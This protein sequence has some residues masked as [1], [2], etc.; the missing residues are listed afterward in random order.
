MN[1]SELLQ[2]IKKYFDIQELV[3][4]KTFGVHGERAWKF[5]DPRLLETMLIL[6]KNI[7]KSIYSNNW[8]MGGS[9]D[10]RGLRHN[11]STIVKDKTK[12][13]SLYLS[14]H[15]LGMAIDFDVSGMTAEQVRKWI[16]KNEHLFPYKIRLEKGVSWVHLDI[17]FEES[18]PKI[19]EFAV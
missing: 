5:F 18:N 7:G 11:L 1:N 14:G 2:E 12:K 3:D 19:Y 10:E 8:E 16:K 17:I 9:F 13:N 15:V 4:A 6:R